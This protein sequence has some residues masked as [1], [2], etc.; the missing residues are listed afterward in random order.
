M[1]EF[2]FVWCDPAL[3]KSRVQARSMA[4]DLPKLADWENYL[5]TC[6]EDAPVFPPPL[7]RPNTSQKFTPVI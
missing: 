4:S 7:D 1:H 6:R 3:R 5:S 2:H